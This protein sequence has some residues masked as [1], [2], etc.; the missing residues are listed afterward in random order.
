MRDL[1]VFLNDINCAYEQNALLSGYTTFK[2]GG[3]ASVMVFPDYEVKLS[4][5][6]KFLNEDNYQY[7]VLGKGSN[8][9]ALDEGYNGVVINTCRLNYIRKINDTDFECGC[10]LP[11]IKACKYALDSSLSGL[12][13]AYGIPG[14]CGGAVFM[15]A[16]AYGGE[17]KDVILN[18]RHIRTDGTFETVDNDELNLGYRSSVYCENHCVVSSVVFRLVNSDSETIKAKMEELL[19]KRKDKQPLDYPSAGSTFKRPEGYFAGALIQECGLKGYSLGGAMVSDKHAGF[20][21]N[22]GNAT[23]D[24]VLKLIDHCRNEVYSA[25]N[26][27]LEPEV[28][29][30]K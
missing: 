28:R 23:S 17:M 30:L 8:V 5:L 12:E 9:L 20:V 4:E 25:K 18:V 29:I 1:K 21:I 13:F 2:I 27:M 15:N 26:V 24:D 3:P 7:Y 10:G 19:Q 14:S 16:G 6:I 11:L 22:K